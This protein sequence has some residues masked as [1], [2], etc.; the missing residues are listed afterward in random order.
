ML[1]RAGH[2]DGETFR[3]FQQ[4][5]IAEDMELLVRPMLQWELV[6]GEMELLA[7][8]KLGE[9]GAG[10][11]DSY[12]SY[13]PEFE[14]VFDAKVR[15]LGSASLHGAGCKRHRAEGATA[16]FLTVSGSEDS[17]GVPVPD[18]FKGQSCVIEAAFILGA[19]GARSFVRDALGIGR[20]DLGF[21]ANAQLVIDFEH[22]DP[23][24]D[25]A[26]TLPEVFQILDIGKASSGGTLE[27]R[28][29]LPLGV[30]PS[31]RRNARGVFHRGNLLEVP[32]GLGCVP[33]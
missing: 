10:W 16:L 17:I 15:E 11:K 19:D 26:S 14:V 1:G 8:I 20:R 22:S 31:G 29:L 12:L 4:L 5:G 21:K 7:T 3:T 30:S 13:Q 28:A 2:F 33:R 9:S 6:S 27:R 18:K 32:G 23:D 24:R 25:L